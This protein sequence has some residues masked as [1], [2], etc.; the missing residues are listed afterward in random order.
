MPSLGLSD[1]LEGEMGG[2]EVQEGGVINIVMTDLH[3]CTA[4]TN[5]TL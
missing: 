5:T 2:W 4:E 1:D 3:C